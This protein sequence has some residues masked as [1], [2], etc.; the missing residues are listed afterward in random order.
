[1]NRRPGRD[2]T[3]TP[4]ASTTRSFPVRCRYSYVV[5]H[6][7]QR[8]QSHCSIPFAPDTKL[9]RYRID[10]FIQF[11]QSSVGGRVGGVFVIRVCF[12]GATGVQG[13]PRDARV[14]GLAAYLKRSSAA[15][16]RRTSASRARM[17]SSVLR[18]GPSVVSTPHDG[19]RSTTCDGGVSF[20]CT[21]MSKG[22]IAWPLQN[23]AICGR[24]VNV[25]GRE[26]VEMKTLLCRSKRLR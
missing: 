3:Q 2:S 9:W 17:H 11:G 26:R 19:H 16:S 5:R 12:G 21:D 18:C 25:R 1:M 15:D 10:R 13:F 23:G 20:L 7:V 24:P 6:P 14:I 22:A 8:N 4:V